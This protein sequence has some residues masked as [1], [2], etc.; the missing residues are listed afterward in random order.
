MK[1]GAVYGNASMLDGM[2]DRFAEELGGVATVVATGG[3]ARKIVACCR[4]EIIYEPDLLLDGL[5]HYYLR[6]RGEQGE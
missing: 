1:S 4:H 2:I 5:Y 3:A 6:N